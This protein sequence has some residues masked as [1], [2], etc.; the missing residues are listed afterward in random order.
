MKPLLIVFCLLICSFHAFS[1]KDPPILSAEL[2]R[3][4]DELLD[5]GDYKKALSFFDQIDRND[6]NYT[7]SLYGRALSCQG[8]SQ[9]HQA[10]QYCLEA[11]Q[12][13]DR[14]DLRPAI[15][16][17][18]ANLL[19]DIGE[20][21]KCLA[22]FDEAIKKYPSYSKLYFNK[23]IALFYKDRYAEAEAVFKETLLIN[24]YEYSVHYY[25]GLA[26]IRQGKI[27]PAFLSFVGY[28]LINPGGK[29]EKK[30]VNILAAMASAKDEILEYKN[31]R[32]SDGNENFSLT[33]DIL[34]SKIALEKEYKLAVSLDDPIFRQIQ[35]VCE[36][37]EYKEDDPD[38][39]MQYYVPFYKKLFGE[40]QFEP[41]I[42][43]CF[44]NVQM[45]EIQDYNKKNKKIVERFVTETA[46]YFDQIRATQ[47]L[48]FTK[49]SDQKTVY[50]YMNNVLE[51]RGELSSEGQ[52][53]NGEWTIFYSSGNIQARGQFNHSKKEGEWT[54]YFFSGKL[55]AKENYQNDKQNG[56]QLYYSEQGLVTYDETYLNGEK[57]GVETDYYI[58]GLVSS[59]S[60]YKNGKL[61]GEYKEMYPG[62]Q[63][64]TIAHYTNDVVS[65]PFTNYY[66]NGQP[67]NT[68][69][70]QNGSLEGIYKDFNEKGK[71]VSEGN[72]KNGLHEGAYASY[73]DNGNLKSKTVFANGKQEGIEEDYYEDGQLSDT[74]TYK[75]GVLNG[76][77]LSYDKDKKIY[78]RFQFSN[79]ILE[80][81][82]YLDQTGKTISSSE[83]K[84]K[85]LELTVFLPDGTKT[86]QRSFDENGKVSGTET[87]FFST[88]KPS[89]ISEFLSGEKN[90]PYT[91][92]YQNGKKKTELM[93]KDDKQ[94]GHIVN[95]FPNG[96]IQSE[97]W[98]HEG[99]AIGYWNYYDDSGRMTERNY[100]VDGVA[101]G[102]QQEYYPNGTV[103]YERK[104][105]KGLVEDLKQFDSTGKLLYYDSFPQFT[106]K[107]R[108]V[109][110]DGK[111]L[112]EF[113]YVNG[114]LEGLLTQYY[115][116]GTITFSQHYKGGLLDGDYIQYDYPHLKNQEGQYIAG[117]KTGLWKDYNK[118]GTLETTENYSEGEMN[119]LR[120]IYGSENKI[121][122]EINFRHDRRNGQ[123]INRDPDGSVMYTVN[124]YDGDV[125]EYSYLDKD[126]KQVP[127]IQS[128][129]GQ[130]ALKSF[131]QNGQPSRECEWIDNKL[132][133]RD[134]L[135]FTNGKLRSDDMS[136]YGIL[137]GPSLEYFANGNP[138][139]NCRFKNDHVEG[140]CLE[141]N[142]QGILVSD[143]NYYAGK[144]HGEAKYYSDN[145]SLL[146]TRYYYNGILL[147]VKK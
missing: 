76:E 50:L 97:G 87:S 109:Y 17:T 146:E 136:E 120:S 134:R 62:G 137:E 47:V 78:A 58:N 5:S 86:N 49:R 68:G 116:D 102:Y 117:K 144:P 33:E 81:A 9:Y 104:L 133:G 95:Y 28:L 24:P 131:F 2:A 72:L 23:G 100:F 91:E 82:V 118:D 126:G 48:N 10:I 114:N 61:D 140:R 128:L 124:Y 57:N 13:D 75:K 12:Q 101:N 56:K 16:N 110:P 43:W 35:V 26:A 6:S 46:A 119:G 122:G 60:N 127:A 52:D 30:C 108:L 74:Y 51:G 31:K 123:A 25:L 85:R 63:L 80:S 69:S 53:L 70:Y 99:L 59:V 19:D 67:K 34:L 90:G 20:N 96:T 54:H 14:T 92:Y 7:R 145:G 66:E 113:S 121:L 143:V 27:V 147:S 139:R 115:F 73:Y 38:F 8:D 37:L 125:L 93:F 45:K 138:K 32:A 112:Q 129:H 11:L 65:G 94:E 141:Y 3:R 135:F 36:K 142:E 22:T 132:N 88:G 89:R 64:K 77:A 106:G 18:Y 15:Y 55:R 84:N 4:A 41:F 42:Y 21:E 103:N 29:Y 40:N 44:E 83:R 98:M 111:K 130:L 79:N 105:Y 107:A 1:Q 39:W 71:V